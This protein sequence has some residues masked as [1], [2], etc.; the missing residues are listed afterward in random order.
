MNLPMVKW[1]GYVLIA[2]GVL[3][4]IMSFV[5]FGD[6]L[7]EIWDAGP[8]AGT[9]WS[10]DMLAAFWFAV[11]TWLMIVLG[12]VIA[13]SGRRYGD[14]VLRHLIGWSFIVVPL[15]C[16]IFLPVS[17]LWA[18]LLPGAMLL[19]ARRFEDKP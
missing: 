6:L 16:G 12:F 17:G 2:M 15:V 5:L 3:H 18:F 4:G 13:G 7:G 14:V 8:G 10:L 11:F 9:G 1:A 19:A